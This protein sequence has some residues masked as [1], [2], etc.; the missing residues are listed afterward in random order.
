MAPQAA[1][2]LLYQKAKLGAPRTVPLLLPETMGSAGALLRPLIGHAAKRVKMPELAAAKER[3][4]L[5]FRRQ[6]MLA[7]NR[8]L[9]ARPG[10]Q[11]QLRHLRQLPNWVAGIRMTVEKSVISSA[12][13]LGAIQSVCRQSA[14]NA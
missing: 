9:T 7:L 10:L 11:R 5:F 8:A 6:E 3:F 13:F 12:C 4:C 14:T 2:L 1:W